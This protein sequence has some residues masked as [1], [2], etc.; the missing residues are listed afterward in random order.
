M[1]EAELDAE[2]KLAHERATNT[3]IGAPRWRRPARA[4]VRRSLIGAWLLV[5]I[6]LIWG[7]WITLQKVL[8]FFR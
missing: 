2:R 5:G 6:P 4:R 3:T 8:V 7:V 1:T